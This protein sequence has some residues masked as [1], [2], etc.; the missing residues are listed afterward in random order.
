MPS[1]HHAMLAG[2][3][4]PNRSGG[5][6]ATTRSV[7]LRH[8]YPELVSAHEAMSSADAAWLHMDRPTNL[9]VI[10]SAMWCDEPLDWDAVREVVATR[11]ADRFPTFRRRIKE[12]RAPLR[13]PSWEDDPD[14]DL[15]LHLHRRGLPPP[16]DAAALQEL[17]GD[18]M[19]QPLDR[20]RPLWDWYLIDGYGEGSAIVARMHHCIADGVALARVLLSLT[21][22]Q[23]DAQI[24]PDEPE[25]GSGGGIGGLLGDVASAPRRV[26]SA[27]LDLGRAAAHE[28]SGSC[29]TPPSWSTSPARP[30]TTSR[31]SASRSFPGPTRAPCSRAISGSASVSPGPSQCARRR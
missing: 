17:V 28:R 10:T 21:D 27:G 6:I 2:A 1:A 22:N 30:A 20:S 11:L 5:L 9:M 4:R 16:G 19:A 29:A 14:F 12:S 31:R 7:L 23:P 26:A 3:C 13:P 24:E 18:L 15:D 25:Q 8:P